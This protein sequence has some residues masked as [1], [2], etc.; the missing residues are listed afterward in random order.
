MRP[1]CWRRCPAVA[2]FLNCPSS[3]PVWTQ[4]TSSNK[5]PRRQFEILAQFAGMI[6]RDRAISS[7]DHRPQLC[8]RLKDAGEIHSSQRPSKK[9]QMARRTMGARASRRA[10]LKT[11]LREAETFKHF[12][13]AFLAKPRDIPPKQTINPRSGVTED[14]RRQ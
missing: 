14:A 3:H 11:K 7:Q 5:R 12:L 6:S 1:A 13:D 8:G 9:T 2:N 10:S 4:R